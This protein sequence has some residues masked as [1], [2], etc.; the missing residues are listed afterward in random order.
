MV[1]DIARQIYKARVSPLHMFDFP[2]FDEF[3]E[4]PFATMKF[5]NCLQHFQQPSK[6]DNIHRVTGTTT[7]ESSARRNS[8]VVKTQAED[9][10]ELSVA[11]SSDQAPPPYLHSSTFIPA[12]PHLDAPG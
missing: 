9:K 7:E 1:R 12:V 10:A 4:Q 5:F 6:T 11:S 3:D 2:E 8:D